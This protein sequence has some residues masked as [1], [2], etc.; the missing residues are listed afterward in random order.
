MGIIS[1]ELAVRYDAEHKARTYERVLDEAVRVIR[2]DGPGQIGVAD[3]MQRAG[4]THGA[5]YAHFESKDSLVLAALQ[6]MFADSRLAL[7]TASAGQP[8]AAALR[9][10]VRFYLSRKHRDSREAG[11]PLPLL[12]SGLPHM[13][14]AACRL[15]QQGVAEKTEL[16]GSL[17]AK[18]GRPDPHGLASS[19]L[20]EMIGAL[21]L[22][23]AVADS[24]QS[25]LILRRSRDS[26]LTR[27]GL[28]GDDT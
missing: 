27:F 16:L 13:G 8:P 20:S 9:A 19:G 15:F 14:E 25:D 28:T 24:R 10:Y 18:I 17:L 21:T 6:R 7:E 26:L 12:S 1:L 23:R 3:I 22:S 4:L 5:F 2:L 11:C